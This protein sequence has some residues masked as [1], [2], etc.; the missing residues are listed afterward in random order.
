MKR[1]RCRVDAEGPVGFLNPFH[2]KRRI[3]V[4]Y[5]RTR[6]QGEQGHNDLLFVSIIYSPG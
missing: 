6:T 5:R 3:V 1:S 2:V 4:E